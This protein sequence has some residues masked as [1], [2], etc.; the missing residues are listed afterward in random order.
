MSTDRVGKAF[1]G[2][3]KRAATKVLPISDWVSET[4]AEWDK[5]AACY[6]DAKDWRYRLFFEF[7]KISSS[8]RLAHELKT[9]NKRI[10]QK[11]HPAQFDKVRK[12]YSI[13][14]DVWSRTFTEWFDEVSEELFGIGE[15][16]SVKRLALF[17][18][19]K[20]ADLK[21][22]YEALKDWNKKKTRTRDFPLAIFYI[23][24]HRQPSELL[25]S[26][27]RQLQ[28]LKDKDSFIKAERK[29][30]VRIEN[31]KMQLWSLWVGLAIA[32]RAEARGSD[33]MLWEIGWEFNLRKIQDPKLGMNLHAL[34][35]DTDARQMLGADV[36]RRIERMGQIAEAAA[37]GVFPVKPKL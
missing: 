30:F 2:I 16:A 6:V 12:L 13:A 21:A 3:T 10:P 23:P 37:R 8:Y 14:G 28:V 27:R 11:A 22:A 32:K 36:W 33:E 31:N 29:G 26:F 24:L 34:K 9:K 35:A 25:R 19:A 7:L 18:S 20:D 1:D 15:L 17:E 5:Q 4:D